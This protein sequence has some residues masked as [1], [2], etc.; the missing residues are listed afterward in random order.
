MS[1]NQQDWFQRN[2]QLFKMNVERDFTQQEIAELY[3]CSQ[4]ILHFCSN[5]I[6]IITLD[7]GITDFYPREYQKKLIKSF[8]EERYN[9]CKMPRQVGKSTTAI[10]FLL[11]YILFNENVQVAILANKAEISR[12]L[13]GRLQL[14]FENLPDFMKHGIKTWNK[15]DIELENGSSI[16]AKSTSSDSIRGMTFNVIFLDEFAHV[17][18]SIAE[19]FFRST[20]PT[21][22]SGKDSKIIVVSTPNGM[23]M[24]YGMWVQAN[25]PVG[26]PNKNEYVP[27]E[28]HWSEV[29]GRDAEWKRQVVANTSEEQFRQEFE[30]E[31]LGS[32]HTLVAA[33]KLDLMIRTWMKD[34]IY[35]E[36]DLFVYAYPHKNHT[37]V[38]TVDVSEGLQQ[39]YSAI[40]VIDVTSI[41]YKV[42]AVWKS[43]TVDP[44]ILPNYIYKISQGYNEAFVLVEINSIGLQV[45]NAM[46]FDLEYENLVK[47][48]MK[49]AQ[50]QTVSGGFNSR[51]QLGV[52][53]TA[54]VKRMGCA[55]LKSLIE[56]D[57]LIVPD[58]DA[59]YELASFSVRK[60]TYMAEEGNYDD[61]AM[62][63]V[64][65][66]W[67]VNQSYF[68]EF[69]DT[70]I[71][72]ELERDVNV[73]EQHIKIPIIID[74][75]VR[76]TEDASE[77]NEFGDNDVWE[78]VL[79]TW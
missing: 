71:R 54:P 58:R 41:P 28:V 38:C 42:V 57:K 65:F 9:I 72:K 50:G 19:E 62:C 32:T 67:L 31:F 39:D 7:E 27:H 47:M 44:I 49:A 76:F 61:L 11:H 5:Y 53:T 40:T 64:H 25:L 29:P 35:K 21:I 37:Y 30:C 78:P 68:K 74:D 8:Q 1:D 77:M 24:F 2:R 17:P 34:P 16:T 56:N 45:A 15:G 4:D 60:N 36:D 52:K 75:G 79:H 26:D 48:Q 73:Q 69:I 6:K 51:Y 12:E 14:A 10:A 63:L 3:R 59:I 23:N 20:Y 22:T 70:D 43:N 13:L 46:H 18:N 33:S 66:A 55:N